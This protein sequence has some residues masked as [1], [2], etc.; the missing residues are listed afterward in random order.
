MA[1]VIRTIIDLEKLKRAFLCADAGK[2]FQLVGAITEVCPQP[3]YVNLRNSQGLFESENNP[4][5][6][7]TTCDKVA[8]ANA[9]GL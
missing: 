6:Y 1:K 9:D 7:I 4:L 8:K 5:K 3:G 2:T